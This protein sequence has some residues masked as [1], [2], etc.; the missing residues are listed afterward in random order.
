MSLRA[1]SYRE[2]GPPSRLS[3]DLEAADDLIADFERGLAK[4]PACLGS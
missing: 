2:P 4:V 1:H 3:V